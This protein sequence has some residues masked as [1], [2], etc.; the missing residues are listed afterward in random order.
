VG[1]TCQPT[2]EGERRWADGIKWAGSGD[3]GR[4]GEEKEKGWGGLV[5]LECGIR[6]GFI[7]FSFLLFNLLFKK[8]FKFFKKIF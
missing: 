4:Y 5:G 7:Y 3:M 8:S 6:F 1:S 2:R